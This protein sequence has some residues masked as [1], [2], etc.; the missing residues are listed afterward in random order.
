MPRFKYTFTPEETANNVI[1]DVYE[2]LRC[3]LYHDGAARGRVVIRHDTGGIGFVLESKHPYEVVT[4]TIDPWQV[5]ERVKTHFAGFL[6]AVR[7]PDQKD[8][9]SK[10]EAVFDS[11]ASLRTQVIPPVMMP[12]RATST[13]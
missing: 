9:R 12:I 13:Y 10:F 8:L 3:G 5:L 11:R 2:Q 4:I 6:A 1:N 7:E